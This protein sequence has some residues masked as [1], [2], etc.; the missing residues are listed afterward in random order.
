MGSDSVSGHFALKSALGG[1]TQ[2]SY[3]PVAEVWV[4]G[5]ANCVATTHTRGWGGVM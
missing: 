3:P 5:D 4:L 1:T 2:E